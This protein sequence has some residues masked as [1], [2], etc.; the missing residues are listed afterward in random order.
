M[1]TVSRRH[2]LKT[3][4][5]LSLVGAAPLGLSLAAISRASASA[6][7]YAALV[8]INMGG[9]NDH[10]NTLIPYDASSYNDYASAR[11]QIAIP[12][13]S[14]G[15][16]NLGPVTSQGGQAFALHPALVNLK[17]IWNQGHL[18]VVGNV[19]PLVVPTTVVQY[20][21][22]AVPLPAGL[23][24]HP[25]QADEWARIRAGGAAE[26][27]GWGGRI[28][29]LI[30]GQN[31]N[32]LFTCVSPQYDLWLAGNSLTQYAL[33]PNA[34]ALMWPLG[35]LNDPSVTLGGRWPNNPGVGQAFQ[36]MITAPSSNLLQ[37]QLAST[38]TQSLTAQAALQAHFP[39]A[40]VF[41]T[42]LP[43]NNV[44]AEELQT[45]ARMM[46]ARAALG[47]RRQ[48]CMVN[49]FGGFDFHGDLLNSQNRLLKELDDALGA[50]YGWLGE[51]GLQNQ[52][53]VFTMSEF[54]RQLSAS[55]S[56][57]DHGW[58]GH[59]FVLGN[60]VQGGIYGNVP[61]SRLGVAEDAGHG[62]LV[63]TTAVDQ[64]GATFAKWMGVSDSD[65]LTI[66]PNLDNFGSRNL[67][68]LG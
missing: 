34:P 42:P 36:E 48:V 8:C 49:G 7:D 53:T 65:I 4:S 33:D 20:Q 10:Y 14:L 6:G 15:A 3:A 19:G 57:S 43:P 38:N 27:P 50:F 56:G 2:F 46:Y 63:P 5:L 22:D 21:N 11:A 24:S 29:D 31:S 39:S 40:N 25:S 62:I 68:F 12:Q 18:A 28:A 45:I 13:T 35:G 60:A 44:V 17:G 37:N 67:G 16:T 58:G 54:G 1:R 51:M 9:G 64:F 32:S 55:S 30:T 47:V 61:A 66:F 23:L 41:S 26:D 59:Q 52:V